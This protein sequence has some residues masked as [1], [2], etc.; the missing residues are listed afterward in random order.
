MLRFNRL[1]KAQVIWH[2][3]NGLGLWPRFGRPP[4]LAHRHPLGLTPVLIVASLAYA[5]AAV[6][7]WLVDYGRTSR[8]GSASDPLHNREAGSRRY[9]G[10]SS[11]MWDKKSKKNLKLLTFV[12]WRV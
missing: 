8:P 10:S 12:I 3:R 5:V 9:H 2:H 6:L 1:I 4:H 11:V 7:A